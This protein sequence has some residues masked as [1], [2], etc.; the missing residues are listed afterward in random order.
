MEAVRRVL[1]SSPGR[2][3]LEQVNQ[4][5]CVSWSGTGE[6]GFAWV[7]TKKQLEKIVNLLRSKRGMT[8]RVESHIIPRDKASLIK[9][10]SD[11]GIKL[12]S[13]VSSYSIITE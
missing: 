2:A 13:P 5:H 1:A 4:V 11:Q 7:E 6:E 12:Q 8:V 10:L 3:K 9:W